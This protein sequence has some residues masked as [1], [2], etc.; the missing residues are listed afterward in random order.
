VSDYIKS[1]NYDQHQIIK[2]ILKLHCK[3]DIELDATYSTGN[4]YKKGIKEPIYKFD[5]APRKEGV[6]QADARNLPIEDSSISTMILDFP[7]LA[8]RGKSLD[9]LSGDR[10]NKTVKRFGWY[11]TEKG[12][13]ELYKDSL[14]EAY[15]ILKKDGILI[16][17][18]QGKVSSG[19]QYMSH[20]YTMNYAEEAGFYIKDEFILLAKNRMVP[21]WHTLNQRNA[22]KHHSFLLVFQK[23]TVNLG[24]EKR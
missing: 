16:F 6:V 23:K 14:K 13:F 2:D 20:H 4:F 18:M 5:I 19:R 3:T 10:I 9:D 24:I 11:P 21:H 15:R 12:L 8:T 17:K 1:I 22:R 7:F